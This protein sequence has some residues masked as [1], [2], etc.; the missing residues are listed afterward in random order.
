MTSYLLDDIAV[1]YLPNNTPLVFGE[2]LFASLL[3]DVGDDTVNSVNEYPGMKGKDVFGASNPLP[4]ISMPKIQVISRGL[5]E[6]YLTVRE[7]AYIIWNALLLITNLSIN[8]T[9]YQRVESI[10]SEPFFLQRDDSR[11]VY[12]CC[13][14]QIYR[15]PTP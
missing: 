5:E 10:Q 15:S 11:R 12:F 6:D 4:A 1:T 9:L 3:P 14:Y 8:G 13:N 7:N 2:N